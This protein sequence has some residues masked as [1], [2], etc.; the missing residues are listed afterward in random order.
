MTIEQKGIAGLLTEAERDE[1]RD[2][3]AGMWS[4]PRPGDVLPPYQPSEASSEDD[5]RK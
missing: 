5:G 3:Y 2:D 4:P 1:V